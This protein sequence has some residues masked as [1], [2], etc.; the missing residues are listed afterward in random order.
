[1]KENLTKEELDEIIDKLSPQQAHDLK[2]KTMQLV[3]E[4]FDG[5]EFQPLDDCVDEHRSHYELLKALAA[6]P[7]IGMVRE[8]VSHIDYE[9]FAKLMI[10]LGLTALAQKDIHAAVQEIGQQA[11]PA[12]DKPKRFEVNLSR[13]PKLN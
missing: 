12:A 4:A 6:G 5:L 8:M 13:L 9:D 1:M 7:M 2:E 11:K 3:R 10:F